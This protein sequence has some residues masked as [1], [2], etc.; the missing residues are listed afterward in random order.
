[1]DK[2]RFWHSNTWPTGDFLAE[3][4]ETAIFHVDPVLP[5]AVLGFNVLTRHKLPYLH[6]LHLSLT[7]LL[8]R[9]LEMFLQLGDYSLF[10]FNFF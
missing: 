6:R 8:Q 3:F 2:R 7:M 1:M 5:T 10:A 4:R 9:Y